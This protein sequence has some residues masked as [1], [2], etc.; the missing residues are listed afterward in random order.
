MTRL[1]IV[2][3][4][5]LMGFWTRTTFDATFAVVRARRTA[6]TPP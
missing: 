2:A 6:R 4:A 3:Y 1:A 5:A